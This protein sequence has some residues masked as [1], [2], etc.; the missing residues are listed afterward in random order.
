[1]LRRLP[2]TRPSQPGC[3]PMAFASAALSSSAIALFC[4]R[5]V[6]GVVKMPIPIVI[7]RTSVNVSRQI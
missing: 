3:S 5:I 6:Q 1:M 2:S 4:F 7:P